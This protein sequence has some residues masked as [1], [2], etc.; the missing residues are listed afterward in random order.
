MALTPT[1]NCCWPLTT[2]RTRP[3]GRC[4]RRN[5][6]RNHSS[7]LS[8]SKITIDTTLF[9]GTPGIGAPTWDPK[10]KRFYVSVPILGKNRG[11][12]GTATCDGGLMVIDPNAVTPGTYVLG[13]FNPATNIGRPAT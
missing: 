7:V 11:V 12:A 9:P 1:A 5:G 8:L 3:S 10:T 6:D 13:A 2:P 4:A